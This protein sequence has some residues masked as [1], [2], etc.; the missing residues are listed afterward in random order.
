MHINK[1][2]KNMKQQKHSLK[3]KQKK[4]GEQTKLRHYYYQA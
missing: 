3:Q 1:N 2:K 4:R